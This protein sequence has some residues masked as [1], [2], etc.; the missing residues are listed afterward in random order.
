MFLFFTKILQ[1]TKKHKAS[2]TS[3]LSNAKFNFVIPINTKFNFVSGI[4]GIIYIYYMEIIH[5]LK[6]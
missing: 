6:P 3:S 5:T 1:K 4:L 2:K